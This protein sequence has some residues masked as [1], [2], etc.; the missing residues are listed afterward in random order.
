MTINILS[1]PDNKD[2]SYFSYFHIFFHFIYGFIFIYDGQL[3][4]RNT[5]KMFI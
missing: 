5:V 3:K 4:V 2:Y 1:V